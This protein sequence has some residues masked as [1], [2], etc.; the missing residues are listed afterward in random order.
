MPE[1]MRPS[2]AVDA[3]PPNRRFERFLKRRVMPMVA[4]KYTGL[5]INAAKYPMQ[6][7]FLSRVTQTAIAYRLPEQGNEAFGFSW[8]CR[9][10]II[11][12]P[13]SGNA[14]PSAEALKASEVSPK[15]PAQPKR[16]KPLVRR[17]TGT[18]A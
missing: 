14:A 18:T 17:Q 5:R 4:A 8:Q 12:D 3:S 10:Y 2:P 11:H 1:G 15:R 16:G 9:A 7:G 13:S 6:I